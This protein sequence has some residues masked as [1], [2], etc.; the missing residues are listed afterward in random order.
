MAQVLAGSSLHC[1]TL[2]GCQ[3]ELSINSSLLLKETRVY[4]LPELLNCTLAVL[5]GAH[6]G[7]DRMQDQA[8]E[9]VYWPGIDA[10]IA[11]YICQCT[12]C[13]YYK[14]SPLHSQCFLETYLMAP[15]RRSQ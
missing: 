14:G 1:Q 9:A 8:R 12:I 5:Y 2:L 15:G 4:I 13:T 7:I 10:D 6:Q 3:D 11:N